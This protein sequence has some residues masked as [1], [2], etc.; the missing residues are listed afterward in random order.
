MLESYR[1]YDAHF[2]VMRMD[3]MSWQELGHQAA[4]TLR[5]TASDLC[6][7]LLS[8]EN[9]RAILVCAHAMLEQ[10]FPAAPAAQPV[11]V[12]PSQPLDPIWDRWRNGHHLF[13][14]CCYF[15][16]EALHGALDSLAGSSAAMAYTTDFPACRYR[17]EIRNAMP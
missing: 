12:E 6:Q 14:L 8:R 5:R 7:T 4:S 11:A 2:G 15:G 17:D 1:V 13:A 16:R 9:Y 10:T 3:Q